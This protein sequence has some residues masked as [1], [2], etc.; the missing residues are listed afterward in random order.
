MKYDSVWREM[1]IKP[2]KGFGRDDHNRAPYLCLFGPKKKRNREQEE[3][4]RGPKLVLTSK[5]SSSGG[6]RVPNSFLFSDSFSKILYN[7]V[8][9]ECHMSSGL[10]RIRKITTCHRSEGLIRIVLGVTS[11]KKYLIYAKNVK[12]LYF[13]PILPFMYQ[14]I[15]NVCRFSVAYWVIFYSDKKIIRTFHQC[16]S[17]NARIRS[18]DKVQGC[19]R[20]QVIRCDRNYTVIAL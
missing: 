4:G 10:I 18:F 9:Y 12:I 2:C 17:P 3:K 15:L 20:S 1:S 14:Y 8:Q 16:H 19:H 6:S 7:H 11:P 5:K 13:R